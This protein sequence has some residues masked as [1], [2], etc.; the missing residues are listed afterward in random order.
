MQVCL[1]STLQR[2]IYFNSEEWYPL[3]I[4]MDRVETI[5][6]VVE[7]NAAIL[8]MMDCLEKEAKSS[9]FKSVLLSFH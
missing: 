4:N 8:L 2:N 9:V 7:Q 5:V 6:I 3:A 1:V